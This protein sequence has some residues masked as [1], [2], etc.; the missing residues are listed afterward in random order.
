M[1]ITYWN[2]VVGVYVLNV[3]IWGILFYHFNKRL[4][5]TRSET[6]IAWVALVVAT[7][8]LFFQ[9]FYFLFSVSSNPNQAGLFL[10]NY[11]GTISLFWITPK[12]ALSG[13]GFLLIYTVIKKG[14][15]IGD[16]IVQPQKENTSSDP[17]KYEVKP[18]GTYLILQDSQDTG[19]DVFADYVTHGMH[20]MIITRKHPKEVRE[21]YG[22]QK[23]PI[24]W[25]TDSP[26]DY[27]QT[28]NMLTDLSILISTFT[29]KTK[30]G[31]LLLD[32]L[33]YLVSRNGFQAVY[34]FIQQKRDNIAATNSRCIFVIDTETFEKKELALLRRELE[35]LQYYSRPTVKVH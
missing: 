18:S 22:L 9:E 21:R 14:R 4:R 3:I 15:Q 8:V 11:F 33:E 34:Q 26:I 2:S 24:V 16:F 20:G 32:G 19:Y 29:S 10:T 13:A 7:G 1:E 5:Q 27:E 25:L 6:R 12:I 17:P 23:T 28:I 31:I 30:N 35:T